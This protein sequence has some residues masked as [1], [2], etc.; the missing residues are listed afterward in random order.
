MRRNIILIRPI[1]MKREHYQFG[2]SAIPF[3]LLYLAEAL[4]GDGYN[5]N[6]IDNKDLTATLIDVG[7]FTNLSTIAFG[8]S[9]MS[10]SQLENAMQIATELKKTYK[11]IPIIWGGVHPTYCT[12]QTIESDLVDYVIFGE[13][14]RSLPMLLKLILNNKFNDNIAY[15]G[16][17][18]KINDKISIGPNIGYTSLSKKCFNIPY[19]LVD[20]NMYCRKLNIGADREF[21]VW[22]SRGCPF[23]CRFCSN[24]NTIWSNRRVR[25]HSIE[26]IV[27]DVKIL[28]ERF[29]ADLINFSD[30][31]FIL[32]EERLISIFDALRHEGIKTK[33]KFTGRVDQLLKLRRTTYEMLKEEGVICIGFA[34]ESGS[35]KILNYM[36]KGITVNQIYEINEILSVHGFFKSTNI[37]IGTPEETKDDLYLTLKLVCYLARSSINYPSPFPFSLNKYIPLPGTEM[38]LDAI[39]K[40]FKP[41]QDLEDWTYFDFEDIERTLARIRPWITPEYYY[42]YFSKAISLIENLNDSMQGLGSDREKIKKN[43]RQ[44]ACCVS[45]G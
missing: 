34:P 39:N 27:N 13:G 42:Q 3:G 41:P 25:L 22:T 24:S 8:I 21:F 26:N 30:E 20:M 12:K 18:R 40:G 29:G 44:Y 23:K 32:S 17:A 19:H 38:Y 10:G 9:T 6:I 33:Y 43:I 15:P 35:Q 7:K 37:L 36:G 4:I 16:I 11:S 45:S 31:N 1:P 5:V 14:E 28:T 2:K